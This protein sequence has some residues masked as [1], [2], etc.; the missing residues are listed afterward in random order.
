MNRKATV[1]LT[2]VRAEF[3]ATI[4]AFCTWI[5]LD[6]IEKPI[7]WEMASAFRLVASLSCLGCFIF[8]FTAVWNIY[9]QTT[10]ALFHLLSGSLIIIIPTFYPRYSFYDTELVLALL[11]VVLG[12]FYIGGLS[13]HNWCFL[14]SFVV[15]QL[16]KKMEF[17]FHSF[18]SVLCIP[19][20]MNNIGHEFGFG[21]LD[22]IFLQ[23]QKISF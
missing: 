21:F 1:S 4:L 2:S 20:L 10:T 15:S 13:F 19:Q 7:G 11:A 3:L 9:Q 23:I 17:F 8:S 18:S 5:Y 6:M 22:F 16:T 14:I 12:S